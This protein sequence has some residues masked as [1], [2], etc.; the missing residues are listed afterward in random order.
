MV[1]S[2]V[3][4]RLA[5][6]SL[7]LRSTPGW[8]AFGVPQM[9][10]CPSTTVVQIS[11]VRAAF[12]RRPVVT[13]STVRSSRR[14]RRMASRSSTAADRTRAPGRRR[15]PSRGVAL[16]PHRFARLHQ[17]RPSA[18]TPAGPVGDVFEGGCVSIFDGAA[19]EML[20][21]AL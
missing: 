12:D 14:L 18:C 1:N 5:S 7:G 13:M 15:R 11:V 21:E 3:A 16:G 19:E 4:T 8:L 9:Y 20:L 17:R 10:V 6:Q 2:G